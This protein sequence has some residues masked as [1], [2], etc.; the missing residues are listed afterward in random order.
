MKNNETTTANTGD[1]SHS[2][3]GWENDPEKKKKILKMLKTN[4]VKDVVD[5]LTRDSS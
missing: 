5:Q 3:H 4:S 1:V 2:A